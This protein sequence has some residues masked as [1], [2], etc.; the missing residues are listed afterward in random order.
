MNQTV[1]IVDDER[2]ARDKLRSLLS[3]CSGYEVMDEASSSEEAID[4][5]CHLNPDVVFLDIKL[6]GKSGI[7]IA[8][9]TSHL[10]Y[11]LIFVTAFND[12]AIDAFETQ[13]IDYLQKPL[14]LSRLKKA[15]EK[16]ER[17]DIKPLSH[18]QD[19]S[20]D[21]KVSPEAN[22]LA[23]K[24]GNA[25]V[26]LMSSDISFIEMVSGYSRVHLNKLG[27]RR[28]KIDTLVSDTTLENYDNQLTDPGFMRVHRSYIVNL[29]EVTA[30]FNEN[31]RT[32]VSIG[33]FDKVYIPV[34]RSNVAAL[35]ARLMD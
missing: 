34:S 6:P 13:A 4:K 14:R 17:I 35:K 10:S 20:F 21:I 1:L 8:L 5:I 27:R 29:L 28:H 32:F 11:K 15:L 30:L 9:E 22:R 16:L 3:Q 7:E 2:Y 23:I 33:E 18:K 12:Y 19:Q 31:R 26:I 24:R 25:T